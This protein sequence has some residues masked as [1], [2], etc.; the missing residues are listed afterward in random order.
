MTNQEI[1]DLE[2]KHFVEEGNPRAV[3]DYT[4]VCRYRKKGTDGC[5]IG[6]IMP[7]DHYSKT[8]EDIGIDDLFDAAFGDKSVSL[9]GNQEPRDKLVELLLDG[10]EDPENRQSLLESLQLWHDNYHCDLLR[11]QRIA[12]SF[13]CISPGLLLWPPT[14]RRF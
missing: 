8:F 3:G 5:A 12:K 2:Y 9:S 4:G 1:I 14:A 10:C 7:N 11:L 13:N 6:I